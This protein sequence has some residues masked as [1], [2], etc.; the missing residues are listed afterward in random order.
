M[1]NGAGRMLLSARDGLVRN[2]GLK[3][4]EITRVF[5]DVDTQRD[6][7]YPN[8]AAYFRQAAQIAPRLARL[9]SCAR[10][11]GYP[12]ISTT[13][14]LRSNGN[15][16]MVHQDNGGIEGTNG[17]KKPAFALL[18]R[19]IY[20]GPNGNTDLPPGLLRRYQQVIFEKRSP[21]PF[22]HPKFDRLMTGM[23][24]SEYVVFGLATEEAVKHTVLGLLARGKLV[25]LVID[26]TAGCD[27]FRA[28]M[29]LKLMLAKGA[30]I[31][32]TCELAPD[33]QPRPD[34]DV[35][36]KRR[37]VEETQTNGLSMSQPTQASTELGSNGNGRN[38][39]GAKAHGGNGNGK[40]AKANGG[41]GCNGEKV[42][43]HAGNGKDN[44][45]SKSAPAPPAFS[46]VYRT[47]IGK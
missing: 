24:V 17:Q 16:C 44:G 43:V 4:R 18:G 15:G 33:M 28:D 31:I 19:R 8:G 14:C 1:S 42:K 30:R 40:F 25:K 27:N 35:L 39:K 32:T 7:M 46:S 47:H 23:M 10:F 21:N 26:A 37:T 6:F 5:I 3:G 9:F 20:F 45:R 29:A 41:N 2:G 34:L 13:M 12:V 22:E 11:R 38:G 36:L